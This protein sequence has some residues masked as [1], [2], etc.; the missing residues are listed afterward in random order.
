ASG[1]VH[2]GAS[3]HACY[4]DWV[5]ACGWHSNRN[6]LR[7]RKHNAIANAQRMGQPRPRPPAANR[8]ALP[9][10]RLLPSFG[11]IHEVFES[12]TMNQPDED[13][14]LARCGPRDVTLYTRPGCHFCDEAKAAISPILHEFGA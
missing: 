3:L 8:G 10:A 14:R 4:A 2:A 12:Q 6:P 13:L 9:G 1:I 11:A 7:A 5:A